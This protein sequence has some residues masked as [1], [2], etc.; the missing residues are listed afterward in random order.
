MRSANG[1]DW[2]QAMP[3][4]VACEL[5]FNAALIHDDIVD[6][7]PSR[8]G[9]PAVWSVFGSPAACWRAPP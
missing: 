2:R 5:A 6:E 1:G 7:D 4:A 9:R 3:A 8:R